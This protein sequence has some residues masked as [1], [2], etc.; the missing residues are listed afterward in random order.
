MASSFHVSAE[1]PASVEQVIS[2]FSDE[3]YWQ[4]RVA[5]YRGGIAHLDLFRVDEGGDVTVTIALSLFG[6]RLPKWITQLYRREVKMVHHERWTRVDGGSVHGKVKV[7]VPGAPLS[8][9][10]EALITPQPDGSV[11]DY[12]ATVEV[13]VPLVGGRV[14]RF[15][16]GNIG[17]EVPRVQGFTTAWI[18]ENDCNAKR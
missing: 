10:A 18:A 17:Q 16:G 11:L 2:A 4:R 6:D 8:V 5:A 1:S 3:A 12:D 9:L 14:E 15:L 7:T 13:K